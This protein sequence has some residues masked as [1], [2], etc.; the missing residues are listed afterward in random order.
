MGGHRLAVI[1]PAHN[2]AGTIAEVVR[3]AGPFGDVMV[4]DDGS[5]DGTAAEARAAGA[6]VVVNPR[7]LGYEASLD[8][9][10]NQAMEQGYE[11]IVT[12]DADGEHAPETLS[13]FSR[14]LIEEKVPLVLGVRPR[15][16]RFS[17]VIVGAYMRWRFGVHDILCG[18]K[19]YRAC[20]LTRPAWRAMNLIGTGI[21]LNALRQRVAFREVP[22]SGQRRQNAPRFGGALTGNGRILRAFGRMLVWDLRAV[23]ER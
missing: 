6:S 18:M 1:I 10:F 2:E 11:A 19:G 16:Q 23:Q 4:I 15:R 13:D 22:V 8:T 14:L 17:E 5:S 3:R 12:M 21:A 7:N 9:G 20:L